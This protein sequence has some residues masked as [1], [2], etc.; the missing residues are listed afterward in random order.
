MTIYPLGYITNVVIK[1]QVIERLAALKDSDISDVIY[2]TP[3]LHFYG[4]DWFYLQPHMCLKDV[5]NF[6][7]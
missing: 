4:Y 6:W 5:N 1:E 7:Y 3:L 2:G